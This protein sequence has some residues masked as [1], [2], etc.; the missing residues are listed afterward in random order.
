MRLGGIVEAARLIVGGPA[1]ALALVD[2]DGLSLG[3]RQGITPVARI[4]G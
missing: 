4:E 3:Q 1:D 2:A